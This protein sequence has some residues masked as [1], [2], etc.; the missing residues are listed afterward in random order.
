MSQVL[1]VFLETGVRQV[2][3][4]LDLKDLQEKRVPRASLEDLEVLVL[5]VLK[6]NPA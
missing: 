5:L 4:A 3:P 2:A 1:L 6:V